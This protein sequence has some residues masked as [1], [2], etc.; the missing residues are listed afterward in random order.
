MDFWL[1]NILR[2][3][4]IGEFVKMLRSLLLSCKKKVFTRF[5]EPLISQLALIRPKRGND[6]IPI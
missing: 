3:T 5:G 1:A 4:M 2:E 6:E